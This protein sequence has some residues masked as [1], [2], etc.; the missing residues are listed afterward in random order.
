[1][2]PREYR[3]RGDRFERTES[4]LPRK[5]FPCLLV[6]SD[7]LVSPELPNFMGVCP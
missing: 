4:S 1:V 2:D 3:V 5:A 6:P 7:Y